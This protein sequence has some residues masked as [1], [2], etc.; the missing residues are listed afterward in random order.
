MMTTAEETMTRVMEK[1][2][3]KM[4]LPATQVAVSKPV[5]PECSCQGPNSDVPISS[6]GSCQEHA[7]TTGF[8]HAGMT[9]WVG[10]G[11]AYGGGMKSQLTP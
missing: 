4:K 3:S 8:S 11:T 6:V 10:F 9:K 5:A 1:A 2:R 7:G